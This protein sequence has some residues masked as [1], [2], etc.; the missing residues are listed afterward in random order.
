MCPWRPIL[1]H[2]DISIRSKDTTLR[3]TACKTYYFMNGS[4][5]PWRPRDLVS[6]PGSEYARQKKKP[7]RCLALTSARG[8][9]ARQVSD[10]VCEREARSRARERVR[11]PPKIRLHFRRWYLRNGKSYRL[12]TKSVLKGKVSRFQQSGDSR[13]VTS[14]VES[15]ADWKMGLVIRTILSMG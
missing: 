8:R 9:R 13:A 14:R 6:F 3:N 2:V 11:R 1:F 4:W 12:E 7:R 10:G 15:K 5:S